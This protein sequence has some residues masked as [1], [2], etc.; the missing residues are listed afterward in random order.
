MGWTWR[1]EKGRAFLGDGAAGTKEWW[2]DELPGQRIN[3]L[4]WLF[5]CSW[6]EVPRGWCPPSHPSLDSKREEKGLSI[7]SSLAP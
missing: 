6:T 4:N 5:V 2:E 3:Y 7:C 1:G